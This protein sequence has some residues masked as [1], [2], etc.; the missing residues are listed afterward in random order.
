MR[1]R[2]C[3][4]STRSWTIKR[5]GTD[6]PEFGREL[7]GRVLP[8]RASERNKDVDLSTLPRRSPDV[9]ADNTV[10]VPPFLG[11]QVVK[12]VAIDDIAEYINETALFRN[13]WQ[14]R[15]EAGETTTTS[16]P[17]SAR[18]ARP[19]VRRQGIRRAGAAGRL[20]VLRGERR[21]QRPRRVDRCVAHRRADPVHVPAPAQRAVPVHRRLLPPDRVRRGR[22]RRVPHR[23]MGS[24]ISEAAADL[25]ARNEY[26]QYLKLHGVGVE[27]AE[28]LAEYWHRRIRQEWGFVDEDGPD[29]RRAVPPAVPRWPLLVGL[30][31]LPRPRG[32]RQGGRDPRRRPARHRGLAR[33]PAGSTSRSRRPRRSSATTRRRST[34]SPAEQPRPAGD[35]ARARARP[36]SRRAGVGGEGSASKPSSRAA[37]PSIAGRRGLPP[38]AGSSLNSVT[39]VTVK[40]D[41]A[42]SRRR[43]W[44][45]TSPSRHRPRT[46][47]DGEQTTGG[48]P[49]LSDA[50]GSGNVTMTGLPGVKRTRSGLSLITGGSVST[51]VITNVSVTDA[52]PRPWLGSPTDRPAAAAVGRRSGS[53]PS[54][55]GRR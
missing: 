30:P 33:R 5:S 55:T 3:T 39:T 49:E 6:D 10:F 42:C 38:V 20:R 36:V 7:T 22:L 50:P 48:T 11:S 12:G 34:S 8:P 26:Q 4:R 16:R 46:M 45:C 19:A 47:P 37:A 32:Q 27:M 2:A 13:Q 44:P 14:Y 29:G 24:T 40:L 53:C 41:E 31:R 9:A 54:P 35:E 23:T 18:A 51:T 21:R 1:S 17:E 43:R 25:F 28:A 52:N 15:P